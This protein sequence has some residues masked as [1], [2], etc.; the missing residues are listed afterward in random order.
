MERIAYNVARALKLPIKHQPD[1]GVKKETEYSGVP[2]KACPT[3]LQPVSTIMP[4]IHNSER[5]IGVFSKLTPV[6]NAASVNFVY[7]GPYNGIAV[8]HMNKQGLGHAIP[9][10][11]GKVESPAK[12]APAEVAKRSKG[13]QS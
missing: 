9:A 11:S 1:N 12:L 7:E 4:I 8:F 3:Y 6:A 10:H 5:V 2:M 13:E